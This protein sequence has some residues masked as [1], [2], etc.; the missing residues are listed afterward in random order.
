MFV[1]F[2]K[3]ILLAKHFNSQLNC[4]HQWLYN[5]IQTENSPIIHNES[6]PYALLSI[7]KRLILISICSFLLIIPPVI[8]SLLL[9]HCSLE[10]LHTP[11][12]LYNIQRKRCI[13]W[14]LYTIMVTLMKSLGIVTKMYNRNLLHHSCPF[15][16]SVTKPE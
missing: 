13:L 5:K 7:I 16:A 8:S 15:L 12:A 2:T 14:R 4:Y 9:T 10:L 6:N 1:L 3:Q 11:L